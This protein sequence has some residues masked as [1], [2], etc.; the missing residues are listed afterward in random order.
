MAKQANNK[1][2]NDW[3]A[4]I[5]K[6]EAQNAK[7]QFDKIEEPYKAKR[8]GVYLS[9]FPSDEGEKYS[10]AIVP[11]ANGRSFIM[12]EIMTI[13]RFKFRNPKTSEDYFENLK[14][15]MDPKLLFDMNVLD[16]KEPSDEQKIVIANIKKHADL[17]QRYKDLYWCKVDNVNFGYSS[18]PTKYNNRLRKEALTGFFGVSTKWKGVEN[19]TRDFSVRFIQSRYAAFQEKFRTLLQQTAVTHDELQPTWYEDY[20]S[21]SEAVKGVIDVEM[22][23]MKVGGQGAT[24]KLVKLGK[25]P[26]EDKGVGVTG[27]ILPSEIKSLEGPEHKLSHL[28]YY[29]GFDSREDLYQTMYIERFEDAIA[30]LEQHVEDVKLKNLESDLTEDQ[31]MKAEPSAGKPF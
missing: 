9:M 15:P 30:D 21:S 20:F 14:V 12:T 24:V 25:D 17:V 27:E 4:L 2:T 18:A 31:D 28:H 23:S 10:F 29:M 8:P 1:S 16:V 22:G 3:Q 6:P 5:A 11:D 19:S 7:K 13:K 26:I